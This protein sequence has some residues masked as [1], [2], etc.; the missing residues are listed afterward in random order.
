MNIPELKETLNI[1]KEIASNLDSIEQELLKS[2]NEEERKMLRKS[3]GSLMEKL[4]DINGTIP[5]LL[6]QDKKIGNLSPIVLGKRERQKYLQE[7]Q[8]TSEMLKKIRKKAKEGENVEKADYRRA[9]KKAGIFVKTATRLFS[10]ISISL[11]QRKMFKWIN[12]KLRKANMPYLLPTYISIS[13]LVLLLSMI[14]SA[15][16]AAYLYL[17]DIL[18]WGYVLLIAFGFPI[19]SFITAI[20]YPHLEASSSS[21]LLNDE[22]PFA[23]IQMSAISGSGVEPTRVFRILATSTEYPVIAKEM[24]KLVNMINFYGYDLTTALNETAKA[25]SSKKLADILNGMM[26]IIS[27]GG[28]LQEYLNKVAADSLLDYRLRRRRFVTIAETYADIYT[29]LLIAAPLM[30]MLL[31]MMINIIGGTF[32]GM[33]TENL[34]MLGIG[35]IAALNI[36]FLVFLQVSSPRE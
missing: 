9:Y 8:L 3:H 23:I 17:Y 5:P 7:L 18:A 6:E 2:D 1:A 24:K 30:F 26:M 21:S 13:F 35:A 19:L 27:T 34:A 10:G 16:I 15:S 28:N 4:R 33:S 22:L 31:L 14:F 36:G 25:T 32:G 12:L 29:G 20:A 11:S